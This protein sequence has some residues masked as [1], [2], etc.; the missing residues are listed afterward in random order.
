MLP[1]ASLFV[2]SSST[3]TKEPGTIQGIRGGESKGGSSRVDEKLGSS[4][5]LISS[6]PS[7]EGLSFRIRRDIGRRSRLVGV[8]IE[9]DQ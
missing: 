5:C 2:M 4:I 3:Y 8:K 7:A 1:A 9:E 6:N